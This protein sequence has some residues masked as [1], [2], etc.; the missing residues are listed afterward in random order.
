MRSVRGLTAN[1]RLG[2]DEG[3]TPR[4]YRDLLPALQTEAQLPTLLDEIGRE[5]RL[6][7]SG[8]AGRRGHRIAEQTGDVRGAMAHDLPISH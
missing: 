7:A 4:F 3:H 8:E 2:A 6:G 5:S 1:L